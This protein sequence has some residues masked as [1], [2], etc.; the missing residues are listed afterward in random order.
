MLLENKDA[1]IYGAGGNV[2]PGAS[3]CPGVQHEES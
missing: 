1:I 3:A 2:D